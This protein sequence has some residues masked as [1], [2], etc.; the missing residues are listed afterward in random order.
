VRRFNRTVTQRIGVLNDEYLARR[1][2]IGAS[3][4]LWEIGPAGSDV[5]SLRA[6]LELDSGYVSRL[7]R[8]LEDDRLV[9]LVPD[10]AD[11]RVRTVHLTKAGRTELELLGRL[12]DDLAWSL[13]EPLTT[14][15]RSR[16]IEAMGTVERLLSAGMVRLEIEDPTSEDAQFCIRS[17]FAELDSR[18]ESGFDPQQ[19]ISA[20]AAELKEPAGLFL[21]ARL[22]DEPVGCG[23]L[24]MHGREPADIK[25][26]WIAAGVRG[27]GLGRRI[28]EE[29]EHHARRRRI[30]TLRLET[31][32]S[33]NE[34]IGLY[35][36]A[37]YREVESFSDE[38]YAHHWFEKVISA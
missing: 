15:Q 21:I 28:L 11:R 35:K 4:L 12:S 32:R 1:R 19:S 26:M 14:D 18:F 37:G 6:R 25:R 23:A 31:N 36:S 5:R 27:L 34:A 8:S 29:L 16:L 9:K 30:R 17:Y 24:K 10:G 13:L 7:L 22:R 2:P 20:S 3:R 33:L 38:P